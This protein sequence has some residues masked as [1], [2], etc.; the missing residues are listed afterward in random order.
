MKPWPKSW[1][2]KATASAGRGDPYGQIALAWAHALGFHVDKDFDE[3]VC[4][5]RLA[6]A[7]TP[8]IARFNHAWMLSCLELPGAEEL[9]AAD[10]NAGY[11]PALYGLARIEMSKAARDEP[12][13]RRLLAAAAQAGHIHA[14]GMLMVRGMPFWRKFWKI[15]G[16][17]RTIMQVVR[18]E[19]ADPY[20]PRVLR[21]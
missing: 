5:L 15:P 12:K 1:F 9:L 16:L 6:E 4:L 21:F 13:V 11:G 2:E 20:D 10:A 7:E 8:Q 19:D 14:G 3:A 18:I 17:F